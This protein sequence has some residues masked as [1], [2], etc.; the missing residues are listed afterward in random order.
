MYDVKGRFQLVPLSEE[1]SQFKLAKVKR[2]FA[3]R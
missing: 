1:E 3:S 2:A